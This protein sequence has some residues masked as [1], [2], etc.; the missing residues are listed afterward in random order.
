MSSCLQMGSWSKDKIS[1]D[2]IITDAKRVLQSKK[3]RKYGKIELMAQK[4]AI[5][6]YIPKAYVKV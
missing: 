3:F 4:E 5:V 1:C 2:G 6:T